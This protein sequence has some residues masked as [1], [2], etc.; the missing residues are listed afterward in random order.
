MFFLSLLKYLLSSF[1][2]VEFNSKLDLIQFQLFRLE[3]ICSDF[4]RGQKNSLTLYTQEHPRTPT[5]TH[6]HS[7]TPT[8][9]PHTQTHTPARTHAHNHAHNHAHTHAHTHAHSRTATA[10]DP[11]P[12]T[13]PE[14]RRSETSCFCTTRTFRQTGKG[15][16]SGPHGKSEHFVQRA[17]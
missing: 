10:T 7:T 1:I 11:H 13:H 4:P 5:H 14:V 16:H 12:D 6:P 8:P 9:T 2:F 3:H 17:D 15:P